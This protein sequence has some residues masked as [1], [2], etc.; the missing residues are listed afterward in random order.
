M[1]I[2]DRL[3]AARQ[4][5]ERDQNLAAFLTRQMPPQPLIARRH[6]FQTGTLRYFETCYADRGNFQS[7]LFRGALSADLG[8]ADG[9]VVYCLPRD[10]DD[11]EAMHGFIQSTAASVPIIVA[12]PQDVFDLRELCHELVCLRWVMEHTPELETD[13]TARREVHARL[14]IAE[15]NLRSHLEWIFSPANTDGCAWYY[16]G[17]PEGL[18]SQRELNDLLSRACDEVYSSTPC[19]RNELINRRSL[20]SSAAAARRNLIEAMFEHAEEDALGFEGN[21]PER[22]MYETLLKGSRLHRKQ[23]GAFG[24]HPPDAKA[25][26]AVREMWKAI[27][28]FLAQ[29][30][31][32]RLPVAKLFDLLRRPPFGLKD[33]VLPVI[34][35]AVLVHGH[36]QLALYEEGSFVP[37]PNAAVFERIFRSPQKFELQRFR[38]AGPRAKVFRHY[39]EMISRAGGDEPDLLGIVRPLVRMV[40][41]LPDYV[42]KTRQ[43]SETAQLVLRAVR[44][45]RQPDRL[46]FADLP[47]ACG[48]PAFE[49]TGEFDAGRVDTFFTQL[50]SAFAELH[51]A[52]PQL[53]ADIERLILKAFGQEQPLAKARQQ[54][55]HDARRV[56]NVAVDAKLKA[57]LSRAADGTIEDATWLESIATLLAGKPPTHWDDQDRAR[58]EIQLAAST[59]TFEHFRV[60]AFEMERTGFAMLDGDKE[61]LRISISIAE[62]GE[63]ERVV[64]VPPK[65]APQA[66]LVHEEVRRIL[67][68]RDLLDQREVSVA[69]LA[70]IAR[71]LL[72][73]GE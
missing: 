25:E 44:E 16:Q 31:A 69:I 71:E 19:W 3:Q 61:M 68:E 28:D 22:S 73:E 21:P 13:R 35:A 5:V 40:K 70:Q 7:D 38:I 67:R 45:A 52:Y 14:T 48:F 23:G 46:L 42:T 18:S 63:V 29:T 50:P 10:P 8:D 4:S 59:R 2:D 64:K 51:R 55:E 27:E 1:D 47:T 11:R 49:A 56:L 24:V 43:I 33:G 57:F 66:R 58:F 54:I 62:G 53:L 60:L 37:R 30:D 17:Q 32:G 20:S 15:Q 6:Y 36:S 39:A 26:T 72:T 9:R 65:L 41:D 34:L 12:L